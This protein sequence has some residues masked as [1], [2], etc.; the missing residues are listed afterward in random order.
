MWNLVCAT[1]TTALPA[2]QGRL[3]W[4]DQ[5]DNRPAGGGSTASD[6]APGNY[7]GQCGDGEYIAGVAYTYRWNHGGVP[8]A[9]L[10]KPLS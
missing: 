8:D 9:L 4:F 10:C 2:N 6:W 1:S 3:I 7:K 5:G